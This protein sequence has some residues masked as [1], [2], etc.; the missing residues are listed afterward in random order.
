LKLLLL[1]QLGHAAKIGRRLT[2]PAEKLD[3]CSSASPAPGQPH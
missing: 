2:P 3:G 1:S